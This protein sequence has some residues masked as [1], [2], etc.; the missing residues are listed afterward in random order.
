MCPGFFGCAAVSGA[1]GLGVI[2]GAIVVGGLL[3]V[4]IGILFLRQLTPTNVQVVLSLY[5]NSQQV[6]T[7]SLLSLLL[8][9]LP[10]S[11]YRC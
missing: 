1:V 4:G 9:S 8:L 5:S 7:P 10:G 3:R 11:N 2:P 6:S